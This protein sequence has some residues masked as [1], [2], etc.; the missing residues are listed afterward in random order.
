MFAVSEDRA[1]EGNDKSNPSVNCDF[2]WSA[3]SFRIC[4]NLVCIHSYP[5]WCFLSALRERGRK[6]DRTTYVSDFVRY[7][8]IKKSWGKA[9]EWKGKERKLTQI[10]YFLPVVFYCKSGRKQRVHFVCVHKVAIC[11]SVRCK[12]PFKTIIHV[13]TIHNKQFMVWRITCPPPAFHS[14]KGE[15]RSPQ[16]PLMSRSASLGR[17]REWEKAGKKI[18]R[19]HHRGK[20][21][22]CWPSVTGTFGTLERE[23]RKGESHQWWWDL[24][25][26]MGKREW[27]KREETRGR[28]GLW[29][30][31]DCQFLTF[32]LP[33]TFFPDSF[34]SSLSFPP[35]LSYSF[36]S[37]S[38]L[39]LQTLDPI[40]FSSLFT[41]HTL[42]FMFVGCLR[43]S[44]MYSISS[45][46]LSLSLPLF[47]LDQ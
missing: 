35:P 1:K 32:S 28:T 9:N 27:E 47:Y 24:G 44:S 33:F 42:W 14:C 11:P 19:L 5:C 10:C 30:S 25:S 45:V 22:N 6:A 21:R 18:L 15:N 3:T 20:G 2:L 17:V 4:I 8:F 16:F 46:V 37:F 39:L 40:L 34:S 29:A 12:V 7:V 41:I 26:C 31:F 23:W 43:P 38:S 36:W 13:W